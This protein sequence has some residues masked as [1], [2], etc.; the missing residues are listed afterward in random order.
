MLV[1]EAGGSSQARTRIRVGQTSPRS[2]GTAPCGAG[3]TAGPSL[4][5]RAARTGPAV[6]RLREAAA[7][8]RI[9]LAELDDRLEGALTAKTCADL[10]PLTADLPTRRSSGSPGPSAWPAWSSVI[11]MAVSAVS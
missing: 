4:V 2:R 5:S 6:V 1:R 3:P 11:P 10:A 9:D 8:G 7:E